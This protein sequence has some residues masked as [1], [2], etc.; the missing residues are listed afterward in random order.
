MVTDT[1]SWGVK[2]LSLLSFSLSV[3]LLCMHI[4]KCGVC[5]HMC[6]CV[7]VHV[8]MYVCVGSYIC[9]DCKAMVSSTFSI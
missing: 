3:S 1:W 6:T 7:R 8:C 2:Y 9:S 5:V 4:C